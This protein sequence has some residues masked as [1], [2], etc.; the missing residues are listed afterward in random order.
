MAHF[1][2]L[3]AANTVLRVVVISNDEIL[4]E[5]LEDEAMGIQRCKE[6]FGATTNWKQ[7]SYNANI[8]KNYA[9]TGYLYDSDR[10]AFIAPQPFAS[11]S[12]DETVCQWQPP[13]P[14]P[15]DG[16]VYTWNESLLRWTV[17]S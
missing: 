7:T 5:G 6:L 17:A 15:T 12:L 2:E 8:R 16:R 13:K 9:G 4:N 10:D 3:D 1:A 14:F 11:W